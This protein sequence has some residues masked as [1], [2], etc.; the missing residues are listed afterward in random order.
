VS[1]L[2]DLGQVNGQRDIAK[3]YHLAT[4]PPPKSYLIE[5]GRLAQGV[6]LLAWPAS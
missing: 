6:A 2:N 3:T 5:E 1:G 4:D